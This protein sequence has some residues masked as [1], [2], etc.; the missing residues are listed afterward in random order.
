M[1]AVKGSDWNKKFF[2]WATNNQNA[3][4][5]IGAVM[6]QSESMASVRKEFESTCKAPLTK[7]EV[8][9]KLMNL[10][11]VRKELG[12]EFEIMADM[13]QFLI[14]ES[15]SPAA[16]KE[17]GAFISQIYE[18]SGLSISLSNYYDFYK[19]S[20]D[21]MKEQDSCEDYSKYRGESYPIDYPLT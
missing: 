11:E 5:M 7:Q 8:E 19:K 16:V 12:L 14:E 2:A 20:L 17:I 4:P 3:P 1:R 15:C 21:W 6:I 10:W 9:S 18:L 13:R